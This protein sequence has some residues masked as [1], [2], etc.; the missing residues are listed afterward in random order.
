MHRQKAVTPLGRRA[1]DV[2]DK[3]DHRIRLTSRGTLLSL[4]CIQ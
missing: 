3:V 1:V 2:S 4:Y